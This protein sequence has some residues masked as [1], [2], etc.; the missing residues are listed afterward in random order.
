MSSFE[1]GTMADEAEVGDLSGGRKLTPPEV[2]TVGPPGWSPVAALAVVPLTLVLA[3]LVDSDDRRMLVAPWLLGLFV[4]GLLVASWAAPHSTR[5][6]LAV[7]ACAAVVAF[8]GAV[9]LVGLDQ[10]ASGGS[11]EVGGQTNLVEV[12]RAG[13]GAG[14][15]LVG[16]D[17][18]GIDASGVAFDGAD[19]RAASA[20]GATFT[21][22]SFAGADLRGTDLRGARL[23]N[24]CLRGADLRGAVLD[25]TAIS[26]SDFIGATVDEAWEDTLD[27]SDSPDPTPCDT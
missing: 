16:S 11:H 24:A 26:G 21:N 10:W 8:V 2:T 13:G 25:G 14:R 4:M 1:R 5:S 22:A 20:I 6:S 15:D 3:M 12:L 23:D 19:L 17:L 9:V 18:D 27:T 7:L